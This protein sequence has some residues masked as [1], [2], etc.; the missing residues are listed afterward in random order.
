[1]SNKGISQSRVTIIHS[2]LP[3]IQEMTTCL[4]DSQPEQ[5]N[6]ILEHILDTLQL[7]DG[8]Y[9][10]LLGAILASTM[11]KGSSK[12]RHAH[13]DSTSCRG[14]QAPRWK[15]SKAPHFS[16]VGGGLIL[17]FL[18]PIS[19]FMFIFFGACHSIFLLSFIGK[20]ARPCHLLKDYLC[21]SI[22]DIPKLATILSFLI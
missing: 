5:N 16:W 4:M 2:Q 14:R 15:Q 19:S 20:L 17:G 18:V 3:S 10:S 9:N 8:K 22:S 7:S 11:G 1:M 12:Q 13:E 21:F 6:H